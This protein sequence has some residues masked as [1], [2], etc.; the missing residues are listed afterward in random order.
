[1]QPF[2]KDKT[3]NDQSSGALSRW[4]WSKL[5]TADHPLT[6]LIPDFFFIPELGSSGNSSG[7]AILVQQVP[8]THRKL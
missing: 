8:T 6:V 7:A 2:Y 5:E 4:D 3:V 1:M